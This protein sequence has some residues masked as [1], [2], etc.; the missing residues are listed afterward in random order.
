MTVSGCVR[1]SS[2]SMTTASMLSSAMA[3]VSS[4]SVAAYACGTSPSMGVKSAHHSV[5]FTAPL[6]SA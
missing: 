3:S 2:F 6:V 5:P 1:L 4:A